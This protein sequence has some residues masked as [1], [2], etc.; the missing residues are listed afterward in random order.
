MKMTALLMC[1]SV[2]PLLFAEKKGTIQRFGESDLTVVNTKVRF[3]TLIELPEGEEILEVAC[4]D[5]E[6]WTIEGKDTIVYVKPARE[7]VVTNV[8]VITKNKAVYSF[9]VREISK[10]G[11]AREKPDLRVI[12]GAD[13]VLKLRKEKDDLEEALA[14]AERSLKDL[15]DK[16]ETEQPKKKDE[17][18]NVSTI[19][20]ATPA[21]VVAPP[22]PPD[23]AVDEPKP[24]AKAPNVEEMRESKPIV[25]VYAIDHQ[26]GL[27]RKTGRALGRFFR[28]VSKALQIY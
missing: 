12:L 5:K 26:E 6:Y 27:I 23:V 2:V 7:G 22:P 1:L 16:S 25:S 3:T 11:S 8:Y 13:E 19:V 10:P 20:A 17:T 21:P 18:T 15:A 4:G 9:L 28:R 24:L 14:R